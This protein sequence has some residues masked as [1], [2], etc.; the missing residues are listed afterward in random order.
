MAERSADAIKRYVAD[1]ITAEKSLETQLHRF[2]KEVN[3]ETAKIIF[4][5]HAGE[6][7][8]QHE[9]LTGR[10]HKLEGSVLSAKTLFPHI[11]GL[12]IKGHQLGSDKEERAS[13]ELTIT[14][15]VENSMIAMYECL[16]TMAEAAGDAETAE[17]VSSI[18]SEKRA[19]A[20]EIWKLLPAV[21][22][23]AYMRVTP[24]RSVKTTA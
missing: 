9:R 8:Q 20:Q 3:N 22:L 1:A 18:Q 14:Y 12:G 7:K 13:H 15:A 19:M 6:T 10:L 11:F 5:K 2:A 4:E 23:D 16:A 17:L 24:E 21:A